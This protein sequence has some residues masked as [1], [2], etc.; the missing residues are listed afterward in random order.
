MRNY[1]FLLFS[2]VLLLSGCDEKQD[3]LAELDALVQLDDEEDRP[4]VVQE[5][6]DPAAKEFQPFPQERML[7]DGQDRR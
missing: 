5:S 6:A 1:I 4:L 7:L 3:D 2:L